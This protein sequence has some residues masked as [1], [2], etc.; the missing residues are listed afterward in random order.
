MIN[1]NIKILLIEDNEADKILIERQ[2]KGFTG[3]EVLN[4]LKASKIIIPF[5]FVTGTINN[6]E[7]AANS[8][9]TGASGYI[10]KKNINALHLKLLPYFNSII[11]LKEV[12]TIQSKHKEVIYEIQEHLETLLLGN[13]IVRSNYLDMK[14]TLD[15]LKYRKK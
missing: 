5:I 9:L 7:L 11:T 6:E 1:T 2:I 3:L 14:K 15:T 12:I 8:I 4:Y 10:L 13:S